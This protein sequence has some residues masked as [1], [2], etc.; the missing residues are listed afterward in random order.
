MVLSGTMY[1][2][3]KE[4]FFKSLPAPGSLDTVSEVHNAFSNTNYYWL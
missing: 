2:L 4:E 1:L 3:H